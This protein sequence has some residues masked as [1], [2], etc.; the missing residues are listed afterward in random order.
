MLWYL[1]VHRVSHSRGTF[2]P[3]LRLL[4]LSLGKNL[5]MVLT[6]PIAPRTSATELRSFTRL[7]LGC[8]VDESSFGVLLLACTPPSLPAMAEHPSYPWP[9]SFVRS[10]PNFVHWAINVFAIVSASMC[11]SEVNPRNS[12][13]IAGSLL[14]MSTKRTLRESCSRPDIM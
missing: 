1:A 11:A 7:S 6:A 13:R 14:V 8:A 3:R 5:I 10:S 2:R 12:S 9:S 4:G